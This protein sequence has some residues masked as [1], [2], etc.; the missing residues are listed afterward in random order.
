MA[1]ILVIDDDDSVRFSLTS[2]LQTFGHDV[3]TAANGEEGLVKCA[4]DT[5]DVVFCDLI[6]PVKNGIDTIVELKAEY[7]GIKVLAISGGGGIT[8]SFDYLPIA[9]LIGAQEILKKPFGLKELREAVDHALS[10]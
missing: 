7:P 10:N 3:E 4:A 9:K 5:Y 6:M 1:K 8:G 2:V